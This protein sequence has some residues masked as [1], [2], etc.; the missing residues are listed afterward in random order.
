MEESGDDSATYVIGHIYQSSA[1]LSQDLTR[2]DDSASY[3]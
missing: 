1:E 2:L 3:L